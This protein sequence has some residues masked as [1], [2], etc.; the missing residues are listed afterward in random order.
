M[1][2][3]R[4]LPSAD[5]RPAAAVVWPVR[6][7]RAASGGDLSALPARTDRRGAVALPVRGS[8]ST[9]RA[10]TQVRGVEAGGRGARRGDGKIVRPERRRDHVGSVVA[11]EEGGTRVRPGARA[12][13]SR[14]A[15]AGPAAGATAPARRRRRS[16]GP[17]RGRRAPAGDARRLRGHPAGARPRPARRRRPDHGRHRRSVRER[18]RRRG[19][20]GGLRAH[21]RPSRFR[22]GDPP[23]LDPGPAFGSVVAR[24]IALRKSKPA[25]GE[26]THVSRPLVGE[27]GAV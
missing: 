11:P 13:A 26:A 25:A 14:R 21:G 12:R 1:A 24:R 9:R 19:G 8:R 4:P 2:L 23:I 20:I 3:L 27:H 10:P 6:C 17:S 7:A 5:R 18:A 22:G 15:T 16:A